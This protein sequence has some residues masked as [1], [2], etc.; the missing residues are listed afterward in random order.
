VFA[1]A[2]A[3]RLLLTFSMAPPSSRRIVRLATRA[4]ARQL[5]GGLREDLSSQE[6]IPDY[7]DGRLDSAHRDAFEELLAADRGLAREV[8]DVRLLR[9]MLHEEPEAA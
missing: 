2:L 4:Q 1:L 5:H 7:L 8:E 3:W 9:S 6:A